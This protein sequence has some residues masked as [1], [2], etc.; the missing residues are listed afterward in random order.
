MGAIGD[1]GAV[2]G[3]GT[4]ALGEEMPLRNLLNDWVRIGDRM[5]RNRVSGVVTLIEPA[6]LPLV[7]SLASPVADLVEF[8]RRRGGERSLVW[9]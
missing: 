4:W 5:G 1:I 2:G 7:L 3:S 6:S 8:E 9:T